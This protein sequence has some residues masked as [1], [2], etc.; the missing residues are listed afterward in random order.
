M[1]TAVY[2]S[3]AGRASLNTG[4]RIDVARD[5]GGASLDT[6]DCAV[7]VFHQQKN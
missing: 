3:F 7:T 5:G 4:K 6:F 2:S 1:Y